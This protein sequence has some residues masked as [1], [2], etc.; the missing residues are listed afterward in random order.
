MQDQELAAFVAAEV[1]DQ[2]PVDQSRNRL[3][4]D[5]GLDEGRLAAMSQAALV[6]TRAGPRAAPAGLGLGLVLCTPRARKEA[7]ARGGASRRPMRLWLSLRSLRAAGTAACAGRGAVFWCAARG[8]ALGLE[9]EWLDSGL[10]RRARTPA[11][12]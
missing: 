4:M 3:R 7:V 11:Q 5:R 6:A 8:A 1:P 12:A 10:V 9:G 2:P